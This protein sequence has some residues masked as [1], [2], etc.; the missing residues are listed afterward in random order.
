M[1][2][3]LVSPNRDLLILAVVDEADLSF[4]LREPIQDVIGAL[5]LLQEM[6]LAQRLKAP[7]SWEIDLAERMQ[8][9]AIGL[10]VPE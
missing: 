10:K 5:L 2:G 3:D 8:Q 9:G 1:V 7:Q 6:G 4:R